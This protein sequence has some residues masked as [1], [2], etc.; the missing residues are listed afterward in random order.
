LSAPGI[1][2]EHDLSENRFPL[3]VIIRR[4]REIGLGNV[5][6]NDLIELKQKGALDGA[7]RVIEIGA[8]QISDSLM[9]APELP[10]AYRLFGCTAPPAFE[11]VGA[12]NFSKSAPSSLQ[13]WAA[14][15]LRRSAIDVE[16]DA[17]RLDLNRGRLPR[18]LRG[19]FDLVVNGGTTEHIANQ[20]NAF[21][22]IHQLTRVGGVMYHELPAGGLVD[23]GLV[24]YQPKFF[25]ML[26]KLN[27]YEAL[28]IRYWGSLKI[29]DYLRQANPYGGDS[30]VDCS[31]RVGLRKLH[32][33]PF[34]CPF[35]TG[36]GA[37]QP[38]RTRLLR[39]LA[40]LVTPRRIAKAAPGKTS[41]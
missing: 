40:R 23:H 16:G 14:L 22:I 29:P 34:V 15:G 12:A 9:M 17:I 24:S 20:M 3:F 31:L 35:D 26:A 36:D 11:P 4:V 7:T 27:G 10:V 1:L 41:W 28:Y 37:V 13:F 39:G 25:N 33:M 30:V 8:Q 6:L 18:R 38:W 21:R 2:F 5:F 19:A 32:S